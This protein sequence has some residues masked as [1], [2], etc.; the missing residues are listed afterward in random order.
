MQAETESAS[1]STPVQR[2][3][4]GLW[5]PLV[6]PF[7][8]DRIDHAALKR[9]VAHYRG[10]GSAG[11]VVCGSTGEAAALSDEEQMEVLHAVLAEARG[12]PVIMGLSGYHL[13]K[14]AA[15]IRALGA[16]GISGILLPAPSY[17]RPSQAGLIEW[18]GALADASAVPLILYDIPYRTG[19]T[20]DLATLLALASHPRICAIKDC[21]GDPAKTQALIADGRLQVLAG[22]D[23]NIFSTVSQGGHGA[24]AAAAHVH[25]QRFVRIVELLRAGETAQANALW[26]PLLPLIEGLFSEP[27][28]GPLKALMAHQGLLRDGL[29]SPMTRA[30][31]ALAERLQRL[32]K[33]IGS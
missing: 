27:N 12:L 5:I 20:L 1:H 10:S 23:M 6:T 26:A 14:T 33:S 15:R 32:D 17:I 3:F 28:P 11:L 9:L 22:E 31:A 25:T 18:F 2:D 30:S 13:G 4:S 16:E 8:G 7:D 29:R 21:G 24:I 19:S